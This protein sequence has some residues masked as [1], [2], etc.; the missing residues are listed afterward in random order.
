MNTE[1]IKSVLAHLPLNRNLIHVA[2]LKLYDRMLK[3]ERTC[4][5]PMQGWDLPAQGW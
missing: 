3:D 4:F 2:L 1:T 5:P